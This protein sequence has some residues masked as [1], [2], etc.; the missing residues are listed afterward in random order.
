[1]TTTVTLGVVGDSHVGKTSLIITY[2]TS[3]FPTGCLTSSPSPVDTDVTVDDQAVHLILNDGSMQGV[4][5]YM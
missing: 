3:T 1:M 4:G 5:Y 2:A